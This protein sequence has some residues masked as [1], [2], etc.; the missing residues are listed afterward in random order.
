MG[1]LRVADRY[2]FDDKILAEQGMDVP[3]RGVLEQ[4]VLEQHVLAVAQ[5]DHHRTQEALDEA[6]GQ[7]GVG[8]VHVGA[9]HRNHEAFVGI[10]RFAVLAEHASAGDLLPPLA[11][12]HLVFLDHAPGLA[13]AVDHSAA[14]DRDVFLAVGVDRG[15]AAPRVEALKARPD[16]GVEL[17]RG[18]KDNHRVMLDVQVDVALDPDGAGAPDPCRH[19]EV[20]AAAGS[21]VVHRLCEGL[22]VER[23]TVGDAAEVKKAD[24]EVRYAGSGYFAHLEGEILVQ[25]VEFARSG[26]AGRYQKQRC[27][28]LDRLFGFIGHGVSM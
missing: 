5:A 12:R 18:I 7:A 25:V 6:V 21:E 17:A 13:A 28:Q 14:G 15:L 3:G 19:H 9:L 16:H 11:L 8:V 2:V 4:A 20:A 22:C 27:K 23:R 26:G 24:A 1:V 10:P